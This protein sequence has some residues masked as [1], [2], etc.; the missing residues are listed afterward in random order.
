MLLTNNGAQSGG[1][2]A[3]WQGRK[4]KILE[5]QPN[6]RDRKSTRKI[7]SPSLQQ[8]VGIVVH[9][10]DVKSGQVAERYQQYVAGKL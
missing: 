2:R 5:P 10:G 3:L 9:N 1:N 8:V 4:T 7:L 6:R